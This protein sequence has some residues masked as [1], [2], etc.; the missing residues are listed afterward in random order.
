MFILLGDLLKSTLDG[1]QDIDKLQEN[2]LIELIK[3]S[4]SKKKESLKKD[5]NSRLWLLYMEMI[6]ILRSNIRAD[7]T[8][9]CLFFLNFR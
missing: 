3:S 4:F 5:T 1:H 2:E 8:G 6:D 7:R 9:T